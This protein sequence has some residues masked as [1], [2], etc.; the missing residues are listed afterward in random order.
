VFG[1]LGA[2]WLAARQVASSVSTI[3]AETLDLTEEPALSEP[4]T[5]LLVG[6]DSRENVAELSG[7][8]GNF[9]GERADVVILLQVHPGEG[10]LQMLSLP[11]DLKVSWEGSTEK[12]NATFAEGGA[13]GIIGTVQRETGIPIHH[14]IQ[15]DFA[16]FAGIVDVAGG[17]RMTFPF[18]ARDL[19]SGLEVA[20]GTRRLDGETALAMARSRSYQ[21]LRGE[22]RRWLRRAA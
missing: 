9:A 4:R 17:I 20:A 14:Y 11:R 3:Q 13:A 19:K 5:F 15:V 6:S 1:A 16:G 12:L 22:H 8:F 10:R 18:P 7:D 2:V 21:E